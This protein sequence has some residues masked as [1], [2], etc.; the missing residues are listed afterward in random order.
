MTGFPATLIP[1]LL[2]FAL[3][4]FIAWLLWGQRERDA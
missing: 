1:A 3:G 2:A 4:V